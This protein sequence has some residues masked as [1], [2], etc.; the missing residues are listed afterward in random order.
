VSDYERLLRLHHLHMT[1]WQRE[2]LSWGIVVLAVLLSL[3]GLVSPWGIVVLPL[4]VALVVKAQD[5]LAARLDVVA[6]AYVP[7]APDSN[8]PPAQRT[9]GSRSSA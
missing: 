5:L 7:T 8:E 9:E 3:S 1:G 4:A 6:G 2:M